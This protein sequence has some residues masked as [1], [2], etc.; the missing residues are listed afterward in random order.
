MHYEN[1]VISI[2]N[3]FV[4]VKV[5]AQKLGELI[6]GVPIY[7]RVIINNVCL[8]NVKGYQEENLIRMKHFFYKQE[9]ERK[10]RQKRYVKDDINRIYQ[11]IYKVI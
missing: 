10:N 8:F 6:E 2:D 3:P 5:D 11:K 7:E 4:Q 1:E 9:R